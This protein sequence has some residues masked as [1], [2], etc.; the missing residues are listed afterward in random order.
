YPDGS[1]GKAGGLVVKNVSGFDM[2]RIHYGALGTLGV[3]TSANF[4]VLP[5]PRSEFTVNHPIADIADLA[6]LLPRLRLPSVR[7]V[8]L[9]V[10]REA[11]QWLL[12]ARYE[13]RRSGLEAVESA[14]AGFLDLSGKLSDA[15][16]S[17]YWQRLMDARAF[18]ET[19]EV[20]LQLRSL[21]TEIVSITGLAIEIAEHAGLRLSRVEIEPGNGLATMSWPHRDAASA[22]VIGGIREQLRRATVTVQAAPDEVK[23]SIDVWGDEPEA[24]DL[25]RRLKQEFDPNRVLNPGRF[26]GRI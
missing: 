9:V 21:P 13:G 20:R 24:I 4:K 10:G 23:R 12:A 26:A 17:H 3:I 14:I 7:P 22:L 16:S 18:T 11:N 19:M 8:S 2:M 25:M 5:V 6:D 1:V 15:A